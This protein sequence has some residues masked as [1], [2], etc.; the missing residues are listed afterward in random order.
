MARDLRYAL[1][2]LRR[3]PGL[4]AVAVFALALGIGANSAMFSVVDAVLLRPLPYPAAERLVA[5]FPEHW[6]TKEEL[7]FFAGQVHAYGDLAAYDGAGGGFTLTGGDRPEILD[8]MAVTP[9][10]FAALRAGTALGRT[11]LPE[12][13]RPGRS[14]VVVLSDEVWR[15]RFGADP[16]ILGKRISLD[17]EPY[18][19]IGVLRPGFRFLSGDT[20]LWVPL[21]IDPAAADDYH[22]NYVLLLGRLAAGVSRE[23]AAADL[24]QAVPR[25]RERFTLPAEFGA[26]ASVPG[27]REEMVGGI[28]PL[29]LV[30]F[31]A[32]GLILLIAC[33][34][35]ASLMLARALDRR[36]E[37]AIRAALGASLWQ[38]ARQLLI[39]SVVLA[40]AGGA[41]GLG[42]AALSIKAAAA[43]LPANLPRG[44][45][46]GVDLEVLAFT[47]AVAVAVGILF[48]TA[49]LLDAKR[50]D[51]RAGLQAGGRGDGGSRGGAR[52]SRLGDLLVV[53]EMTIALVL[54]VGAG[55]L[56][57]SF[58][59]LQGVDPGFAPDR[60]LSLRVET[61]GARYATAAR[62]EAFFQQTLARLRSLPGV[63]AA[64]AI[65][66]LPMTGRAWYGGVR[67]E[68]VAPAD[69]A[70]LGNVA[71]RVV[72]PGYFEAL[73]VPIVAGRGLTDADRAQAPAVAVVDETMAR[74]CWPGRSP[75]GRRLHHRSE[76]GKEW[77]TVVG[78]VRA[79][80]HE[81]PGVDPGPVVYRPYLQVGKN[82]AMSFVLRTPGDPMA[83]AAA[84]SRAIWAVDPEVPV[85]SVRSLR[86]VIS[87]SISQPRLATALLAAF[88]GLA[89]LLG[90]VG[91]YAVLSHSIRAR[92]HEI[93][94]RMALGADR[95]S[96]FGLLMGR[97]VRLAVLGI[98]AGIPAALALSRLL[99]R[100]LF[101]V[102]AS[103]PVT[104][105]VVT[106]I[107]LAAAVAGAWFPVR[108]ATRLAPTAALR[109]ET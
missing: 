71:W 66:F 100:L 84:A 16:G 44:A 79:I 59:R 86:Q 23:Q 42:L 51:P 3:R 105:L 73:G 6:F 98:A 47:L 109:A 30:L 87:R 88:A 28:R 104:F 57:K 46:I 43:W 14:K 83:L 11:F 21:E 102:G 81:G 20:A 97:A 29:L 10:F 48:G 1:H 37:M 78:V 45:G 95:G 54:V 27:L 2:A 4:A 108:R 92:T 85:F 50:R 90:I 41:A 75:L 36:R 34:N 52:D 55:L 107:L 89:L 91:I 61:S 32:V 19:V 9:S 77:A 76:G 60:V 74:R 12:E 65:H 8:S 7:A 25:M 96:I 103:D 5:V 15:R 58:W 56:V 69:A 101:Q 62:R 13:Q 24:R 93:G 63:G 35:V 18:T 99:G 39:E 72:T 49:P 106:A 17:R 31:G 67:I 53:A 64:G 40:L 82:L 94:V 26:A 33:A 38:L 70:R 68:G 22:A 80:R